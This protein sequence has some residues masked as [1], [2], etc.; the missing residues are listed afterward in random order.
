MSRPVIRWET[1]FGPFKLS[2]SGAGS[3]NT[4]P[5][6]QNIV[7]LFGTENARQAFISKRMIGSGDRCGTKVQLEYDL[8]ADTQI[9]V[10][11]SDFMHAIKITRG[12]I[13]GWLALQL[14]ERDHGRRD[15]FSLRNSP[16]LDFFGPSPLENGV[17][18]GV[19]HD[20][21]CKIA[22]VKML[23][24]VSTSSSLQTMP[25]WFIDHLIPKENSHA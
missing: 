19:H 17:S 7:D 3:S 18:F 21:N 8:K 6:P 1:D 24:V 12:N 25:N 9:E 11:D 13:S 4:G 20:S 22:V 2:T 15:Q 23:Y 10:A 14:R 16:R 5:A